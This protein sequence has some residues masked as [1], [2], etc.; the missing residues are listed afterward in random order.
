MSTVTR[1]SANNHGGDT[2][3]DSRHHPGIIGYFSSPVLWRLF[4][5]GLLLTC[6]TPTTAQLSREEI[7]AAYL[8]RIAEN[9][10][11]P[12]AAK[13]DTYRLHLITDNHQIQPVLEQFAERQALHG[14]P[15]RVTRSNAIAIP[16]NVHLVYLDKR[17]SGKYPE[18]V[19]QASDR[20]L[21]LVSD[22][23]T[24]NPSIMVNLI[25]SQEGRV[26]FEINRANIRAQGLGVHPDIILLGGTEVD[27]ADLYRASQASLESQR[28]R[29]S[30]LE[31]AVAAEQERLARMQAKTEQQAD[32]IHQQQAAIAT[33]EARLAAAKA[34]TAALETTIS[35]LERQIAEAKTLYTALAK[36]NADQ[37]ATIAAQRRRYQAAQTE[38]RELLEQI[39]QREQALAEQAA[40]IASRNAI[41]ANQHAQ[42][43]HQTTILK[44]Q[45]ATIDTQQHFL[46][47]L[48]AAVALAIILIVVVLRSY[49]IEQRSTR[50]L[51]QQKHL[52]EQSAHA[53]TEA[54]TRAETANQAKSVFLA[55]MSHEL[56]TPLN[57]ILGFS[58]LLARDQSLS[59]QA[60]QS[61]GI[62]NRAGEHLLTLINE[63]LDLSKIEA[64]ECRLEPIA[65]D[66]PE[67]VADIIELMRIRANAKGLTLN[68][69]LT[70]S[71]PRFIVVDAGKFRQILLNLIGNAI[72]FTDFGQVDVRLDATPAEDTNSVNLHG[73]I[74]DTGIGIDP[75]KRDQIFQPFEQ[76]PTAASS[77]QGHSGTGLG[78]T[79]TQHYIEL[80]GGHI[81]VH[82]PPRSGS[83]FRFNIIVQRSATALALRASEHDAVV[84]L[85]P[86]QPRYRILIVE[87]HA[88]SA[89]LLQRL[90]TDVGFDIRIARN[91]LE[92]IDEFQRW[93][94]DFIWM[95]RRMPIM[96]GAQAT[97]HIR[98][99]PGGDTA[100]IVAITASVF[101][102]Q[103]DEL[104]RKGF[105]DFVRK[106]YRPAE[107]FATMA[108]HLGVRYRYGE[109][110]GGT[111]AA[112][113]EVLP[114]HREQWLA[115]P[116][117]LVEKVA[118]S[119][120]AADI[121]QTLQLTEQIAHHDAVLANSLRQAIDRFDFAAIAHTLPTLSLDSTGEH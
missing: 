84:G 34:R 49:R 116:G 27:V 17:K 45:S 76:I 113:P 86:G 37:Q 30:L 53:L 3:P 104:M 19:H 61:I 22:N 71:T 40:E 108:R 72:K 14:K 118:Q 62:V 21:L 121:E 89:L 94:P 90:L 18:L 66:L 4:A 70:P 1:Y 43:Q 78:L 6:S 56:R 79:I 38:Y 93:Q 85:A 33:T 97:L 63:I 67:F 28:R 117:A 81:T 106:P 9:I 20:P 119:V 16:P 82:S 100:K 44:D 15:V 110:R 102:E 25:D 7:V 59:E 35:E 13:I 69:S 68:V 5:V 101:L 120:R 65:I 103:R 92:A 23:L 50:Q 112:E 12:N 105:D 99:L 64:S 39:Q 73:E 57:A 11:W 54:R 41:L 46:Y 109:S 95:D 29:A 80:M 91:G 48:I 111:E 115:L 52:L 87:D 10:N 24:Q 58:Q 98:Q 83:L 47:A 8:Y 75:A 32:I 77:A 31:Q 51:Q 55:N 36:Q 88:D 42:I 74:E 60:K 114:I 107:V 96:D 26:Q 2:P